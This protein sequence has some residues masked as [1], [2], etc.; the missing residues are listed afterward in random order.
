MTSITT[1]G[2][3]L[4]LSL[5]G[6]RFWAPFGFA[7]IFGLAASTVLTLVIQPAAYITLERRRPGGEPMATA[8]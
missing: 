8:A 4:P 3:L 7:M 5:G 6:G 1:I 2:G